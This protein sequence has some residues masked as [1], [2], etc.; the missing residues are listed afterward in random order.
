M[1]NIIVN[2]FFSANVENIMKGFGQVCAFNVQTVGKHG[3]GRHPYVISFYASIREKMGTDRGKAAFTGGP[4][5][6]FYRE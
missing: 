1:S 2:T 4:H 3:G 5:L 6:F